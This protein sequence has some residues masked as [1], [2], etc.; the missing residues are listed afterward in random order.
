MKFIVNNKLYDTEKAELLCTFEKPW[1]TK[2]LLGT[3]NFYRKTNL[4][5]T[6]KGAWFLTST[7]DSENSY[8][9]VISEKMGKNYL[10]HNA[11][12]KYCEMY[13][14]LEEA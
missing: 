7:N 2:T 4:Y 8:I 9:K 3:M 1:E 13:G 11:Y 10:M 5:K 12:E 14:P 6:A